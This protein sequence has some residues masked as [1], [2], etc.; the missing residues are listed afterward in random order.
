MKNINLL[1][2]LI[3]SIL[4]S[5][6]KESVYQLDKP[7]V[8][9]LNKE[10]NPLTSDP[11]LWNNRDLLF[12]DYFGENKIVGL[13]EATHGTSEFFKAKHR[14]FKYLVENHDFKI[15]AFEADFGESILINEA[16]QNGN[17]DQI[18]ELMNTKMHFW[19]WQTEEVE[20][21]LDWM[22]SY[23]KSKE[24]DE[25]LQYF[26]LDC[27]FNTFH[28]DMVLEYLKNMEVSF[29]EEAKDILIEAKDSSEKSFDSYTQVRFN[30]FLEKVSNLVDSLDKHEN[31]LVEKSS[32][33]EFQLNRRLIEVIIQASE[34]I[35]IFHIGNFENDPRDPRM[36]ENATWLIDYFEGDKIAIWAHNGHL[37]NNSKSAS[38]GYHLAKELGTNY[39]SV[40]FLFSK[41]S[42]TAIQGGLTKS[43]SIETEPPQNTLNYFMSKSDK[44]TFS[45]NVEELLENNEW[46]EKFT[47]GL[48]YLDI[49]AVFNSP[50]ENYYNTYEPVYFDEL[51][52][53]DRTTAAKNF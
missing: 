39:G 9:I 48:E 43:Q 51:I 38:M 8:E 41:G 36:A 44:S 22:C 33:K 29:I 52:Y 53:F 47:E 27:S 13:G 23:N 34:V 11:L 19:T 49:G 14:I 16:I 3:I 20:E 7:L 4:F 5:C 6:K 15:F 25:K 42:F 50:P 17:C 2:V 40:G 12:L 30:T 24:V 46:N 1:L 37:D 32:E 26:G 35:R 18:R 21:L 45:I 10:L 28:P 31:F